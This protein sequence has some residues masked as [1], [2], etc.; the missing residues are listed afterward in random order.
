[1]EGDE[2]RG[3]G[4]ARGRSNR[5]GGFRGYSRKRTC[6]ECS[7]YSRK[8]FYCTKLGKVLEKS[9]AACNFFAPRR[10]IRSRGRTS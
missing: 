9:R 5:G 3:T 1:M 7:K 8:T 2:M 6:E 10:R 4:R